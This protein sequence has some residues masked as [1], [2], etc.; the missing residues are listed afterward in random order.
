MFHSSNFGFCR[1]PFLPLLL[2]A[3]YFL[4]SGVWRN[5]WIVKEEKKRWLFLLFL[6][7]CLGICLSPLPAKWEGTLSMLQWLLLSLRL[8]WDRLGW[9]KQEESLLPVQSCYEFFFQNLLAAFYFSNLPTAAPCILSGFTALWRLYSCVDCLQWK[10]WG[11]V[12]LCY[13]IWLWNQFV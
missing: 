10:G 7:K 8:H 11:G 4:G 1:L 2:P 9:E 13:L 5:G 6:S 3:Q 12:C